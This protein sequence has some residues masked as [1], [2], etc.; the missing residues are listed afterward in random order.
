ML[1]LC[2]IAA[3]SIALALVFQY[4]ALSRDLERVALGRLTRAGQ[5]AEQV[6]GGYLDAVLDRYEAISETPRLRANLELDDPATLTRYARHLLE[7]ES[8]TRILFLDAEERE[9]AAAGSAALDAAARAVGTAALVVA[10]DQPYVIASVDLP[11]DAGRMIAVEAIGQRTVSHWSELCGARVWFGDQPPEPSGAHFIAQQ[12]AGLPMGVASSASSERAMLARARWNLLYAAAVALGLALAAS[13]LLTNALVRPIQRVRDAAERIGRGDLRARVRVQRTDELGELAG[14]VNE[15]AARLEAHDRAAREAN[16]E[17]SAA[18]ERAEAASRSKSDFLANISHE[19]RTP[20]TSILGFTELLLE[21]DSIAGVERE[22]VETTRRNGG[23]LLTL[24]DDVLDI[25]R[26]EAG[27]IAIERRPTQVREIVGD[28]LALLRSPAQEKGLRLDVQYAGLIPRT[29]ETDPTRLRQVLMNLVGNAVKFTDAGSVLVKVQLEPAE[30]P[31]RW[32]LGFD[33]ID[34]GVGISV[35]YL[36]QLFAPFSQAD[37]SSSRRFGGTGLGLAISKRLI[38]CLGGSIHV[39]S[40]PGVGTRF[41]FTVDPGALLPMTTEV[42]ADGPDVALA[43]RERRAAATGELVLLA[44]DSPDNQRL[45]ATILK[46]AGFRVEVAENGEIACEHALAA[47]EAGAP[48]DV[49]LMD[50]QMP[51]LDGYGATR[52][53]RRLGYSGVIIAIT[54]HAMQGDREKCI[55]TGCD[56]FA[57]KPIDRQALLDVV[58]RHVDRAKRRDPT[59]PA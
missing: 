56:D 51:V 15:M 58:A 42:P 1:T 22:W 20:M 23:H 17:L 27:R 9:V 50:M 34:T 30:E 47:A 53:L 10:E 18:K 41:C 52:K 31:G 14:V 8:A 37:T 11:A 36:P 25:S 59:P 5:A 49:I 43:G 28:V 45:I 38:E 16:T 55:N 7:R 29:I 24:L 39:E 3:G 57:V 32:L 35:E 6:L 48:F 44:E 54:A 21:S 33:V 40:E 12:L 19:I 13:L 26:I 4:R 46:R 2:G